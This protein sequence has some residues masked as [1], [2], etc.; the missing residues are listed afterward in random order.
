MSRASTT[1]VTSS[2]EDVDARHKAGNDGKNAIGDRLKLVCQSDQTELQCVAEF[3]SISKRDALIKV[4][5]AAAG[6]SRRPKVD[7]AK[8][9]AS[10]PVPREHALDANTS[11]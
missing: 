6:N 5:G 9:R 7:V 4:R 11:R 2:R 10:G 3:A 8:F 1:F